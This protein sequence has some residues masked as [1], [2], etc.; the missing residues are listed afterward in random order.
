M[1]SYLVKWNDTVEVQ[2][3]DDF[4]SSVVSIYNNPVITVI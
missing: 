3:N 1:Y 2:S 4:Y